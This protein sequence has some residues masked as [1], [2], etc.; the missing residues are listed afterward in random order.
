MMFFLV[1]LHVK[2]EI[3][4]AFIVFRFEFLYFFL[5]D[6]FWTGKF[7]ILMSL[8]EYELLLFKHKNSSCNDGLLLFVMLNLIWKNVPDKFNLVLKLLLYLFT[9]YWVHLLCLVEFKL[10]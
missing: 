1:F 10:M 8:E 5:M 9:F 4:P 6:V 3:E 7:W 2:L